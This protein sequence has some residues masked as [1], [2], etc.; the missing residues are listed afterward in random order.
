MKSSVVDGF[1]KIMSRGSKRSESTAQASRAS[2]QDASTLLERVRA[3]MHDETLL[4]RAL[5]HA[6]SAND[7]NYERLEFL[8]DAVLG[9]VIVERIFHDFPKASE[10]PLARLKAHLGSTEVLSDVAEEFG[11]VDA[12]YLGGMPKSQLDRA[13]T[14]VG[15]ALVESIIGA[16]YL[17]RGLPAAR[18][19]T[20]ELLGARLAR[21]TIRQ[22][23]A[24]DAKTQLHE[25]VQGALHD[26]PSYHLLKEE[27][28]SHAREFL[29]EVRIDGK[30][31]GKAWGTR[32]K[33][34][35]QGAA[36]QALQ[37]IEEGDID[38]AKMAALRQ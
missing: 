13:R 2:A 4:T 23:G 34:A 30:A 24:R 21:A 14:N 18:L 26:R 16:V 28:P 8:G 12:A 7:G 25:L 27:G 9:M 36:A 15:A 3:K 33:S 10:G 19:L 6:S 29:I 37:A 11:L 31:C 35:E 5:T 20:E 17:D 38:L 1:A 22:T 32:R